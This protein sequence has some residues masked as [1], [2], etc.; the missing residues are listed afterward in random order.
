MFRKQRS[1]LEEVNPSCPAWSQV[2]GS[3]GPGKWALLADGVGAGA[4]PAPGASLRSW[5]F[6]SEKARV[7]LGLREEQE[8]P[9][10]RIPRAPLPPLQEAWSP[11][12]GGWFCRSPSPASPAGPPAALRCVRGKRRERP[13]GGP[14]GGGEGRGRLRA[15]SPGQRRTTG[16]RTRRAGPPD[17]RIPQA[18]IEPVEP[19][20][21]PAREGALPAAHPLGNST[22]G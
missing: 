4:R 2:G 7:S 5:H 10:K 8:S 15:L 13:R 16:P 11:A 18:A 12:A 9:G 19:R 20:P 21:R 1:C 17:C 6:L 3:A 14:S 22:R